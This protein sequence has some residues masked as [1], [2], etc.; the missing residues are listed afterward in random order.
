MADDGARI[1]VGVDG[2]G[3]AE[4]ALRWAAE[5]AGLTGARI[6]AVIA[7]EYP[8][9]SVGEVLL[10]PH[11][12]ES[13]AA[14]SLTAAVDG[15]LGPD[16]ACDV[17]QRV[18]AGHPARVLIELARGARLLVVGSRGRGGFAAALLGSVAQYCVQHAPCPVVVVRGPE[19]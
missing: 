16:R 18:V 8:L 7:W 11:D 5:Q 2:S 4:A 9:F 15:A 12:P 14:R 3:P 17:R 6:D 13:M 10:P 1:V 19:S